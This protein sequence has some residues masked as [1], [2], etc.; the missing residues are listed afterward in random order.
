MNFTLEQIAT[1]K[2]RLC[3]IDNINEE[4]KY[5]QTVNLTAMATKDV[6]TTVVTEPY[7]V[8][9]LDSSGNDITSDVTISLALVAGVYHVYIYSTDALNNVKVKLLY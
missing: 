5:L 7:N 6:T 9:I 1:K 8:F 4:M 3:Q 2:F